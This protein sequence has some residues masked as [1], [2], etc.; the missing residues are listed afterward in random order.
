M[1]ARGCVPR[2]SP[3]ARAALLAL[4]LPAAL[5][6]RQELGAQEALE[7]AA[8]E[9]SAAQGVLGHRAGDVLLGDFRLESHL[10]STPI[11]YGQPNLHL[12][13]PAPARGAG[14]ALLEA[15]PHLDYPRKLKEGYGIEGK[16]S[17]LSSGSFG[18][19]WEATPL[20]GPL[21]G[22]GVKVVVK[23]LYFKERQGSAVKYFYLTREECGKPG[24][25]IYKEAAQEARRECDF[26]RRLQRQAHGLSERGDARATFASRLM[27]CHDHNIEKATP[28]KTP[29]FLVLENCG[30]TNLHDYIGESRGDKEALSSANIATITRQLAEGLAF[31]AALEPPVIHHDFKPLNVV[32]KAAGGQLYVKLIDFGAMMKAAKKPRKRWSS[33]TGVYAP[34]EYHQG[35]D[36]KAPAYS[37]DMF[38][39]GETLAQCAMGAP[40]GLVWHGFKADYAWKD[41]FRKDL[42]TFH[43]RMAVQDQGEFGLEQLMKDPNAAD[44]TM[45]HWVRM[46]YKKPSDRPSPEEVLGHAWLKEAVAPLDPEWRM[47]EPEAAAGAAGE[48]EEENDADGCQP[49]CEKC[50]PGEGTVNKLPKM[51]CGIYSPTVTDMQTWEEYKEHPI[52]KLG[53]YLQ[54]PSCKNFPKQFLIGEEWLY[55]W[56]CPHWR[57]PKGGATTRTTLAKKK[58][59]K[60]WAD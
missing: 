25:E 12:F 55:T 45:K 4:A 19:A 18:E 44:F 36:Y 57:A 60:E 47:A 24:N 27:N 14:G 53:P 16:E 35:W 10:G 58:T 43:Q 13:P 11:G 8:A 33:A 6:V 17:H 20:K 39:L 59:K 2:G 48:P 38:S 34:P 37:F 56:E 1:C 30:R 28:P 42:E 15:P 7:P 31:L 49:I 41:Y 26:A 32:V 22:A 23:V 52:M 51:I 21:A 50:I 46:V 40:F 3:G 29:L 9:E 54:E 5:A